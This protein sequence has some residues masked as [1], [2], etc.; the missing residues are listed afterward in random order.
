MNHISIKISNVTWLFT[1]IPKFAFVILEIMKAKIQKI[2]ETS[3]DKL[4]KVRLDYRT[5]VT[6]TN[7]AAL[8]VWLK[9]YPDAKVIS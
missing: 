8:D 2:L 4:I 1:S 6:L 5:F 9:K 7:I 3:K